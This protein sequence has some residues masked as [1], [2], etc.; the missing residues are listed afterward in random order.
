MADLPDEGKGDRN[1]IH[2]NIPRT[3][4]EEL[5][6]FLSQSPLQDLS[7]SLTKEK[8]REKER[9]RVKKE[10]ERVRKERERERESSFS[11]F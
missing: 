5:K 10:R 1:P 6:K 9:E 3:F 8:E 11:T 4:L 7:L 2:D